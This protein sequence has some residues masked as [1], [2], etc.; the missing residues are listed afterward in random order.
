MMAG[1]L[2]SAFTVGLASTLTFPWLANAFSRPVKSLMLRP[3]VMVPP[4]DGD[5]V[6]RQRHRVPGALDQ[7]IQLMPA[8][9]S[10]LS[11]D[12]DDLGL[13]LHLARRA[14]VHRVEIQLNLVEPIG[15]V[16]RLQQRRLPI[17]VEASFRRHQ[18]PHAGRQLGEDIAGVRAGYLR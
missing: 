7:Q 10:S 4:A 13:N 11:V 14:V 3:T 17:H 15:I 5:D 16:G 2:L 6:L 8:E 12:L 9:N 18:R 1:S